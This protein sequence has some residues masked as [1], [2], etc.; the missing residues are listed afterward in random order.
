MEYSDNTVSI[1][2]LR[3]I[4]KSMGVLSW[5]KSVILLYT[6]RGGGWEGAKH[7][8]N[9]SKRI[10]HFS[11]GGDHFVLHVFVHL[12]VSLTRLLEP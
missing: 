9:K 8:F 2:A 7:L 11:F 1:E 3:D 6:V 4:S 12:S 10:C 5:S